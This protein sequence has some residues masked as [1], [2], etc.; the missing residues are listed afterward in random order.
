M[1]ISAATY[2]MSGIAINDMIV[3][4]LKRPMKVLPSGGTTILNACRSERREVGDVD[5]SRD[6]HH[7]WD[8]DQRH[9]RRALE[10]AYEGV[11]QRRDDD[12]QRLQIGT[13]RS[14]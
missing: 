7:V 6:V 13:A 12:P 10:E 1:L 11:A 2:T 9:D 8:R 14:R 3:A 5:L 4:P